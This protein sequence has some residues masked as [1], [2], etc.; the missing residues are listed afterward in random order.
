MKKV[1]LPV[2]YIMGKKYIP[3]IYVFNSFGHY[4][5]FFDLKKKIHNPQLKMLV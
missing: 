4:H 1:A 3:N 5:A 2:K